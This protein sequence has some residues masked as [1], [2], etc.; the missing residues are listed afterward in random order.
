MSFYEKFI[1]PSCL[2]L[3]CGSKPILQQREKVVNLAQGQI[4][5]IG[6]GSGLNIPFYD[7]IKVDMVWSLEPSEGMH[8]KLEESLKKA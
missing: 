2:D 4:L 6:M 7:E 8:R 1:L 5:E 3:A